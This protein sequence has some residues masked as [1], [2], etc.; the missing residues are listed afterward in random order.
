MTK[1][2]LVSLTCVHCVTGAVPTGSYT[3]AA[4]TPGS[5]TYLTTRPLSSLLASWPYGVSV[6]Q[7]EV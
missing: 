1:T 6:D 3:S 5:P 7:V 4:P 2:M